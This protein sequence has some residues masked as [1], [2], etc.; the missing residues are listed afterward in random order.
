[1]PAM[2]RER[3][4]RAARNLARKRFPDRQTTAQ[5]ALSE[6]PITLLHQLQHKGFGLV[7]LDQ[8]EP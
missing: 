3:A 6:L 8:R 7:A 2:K 4:Q 1:M 5:L